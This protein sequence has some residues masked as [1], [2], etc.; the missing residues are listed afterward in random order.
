MKIAVVG[1]R[2][3]PKVQ[4][5]IETHCEKLYTHLAKNGCDI[6]VFTR[7]PYVSTN[8]HTF[9]GVSLIPVNCPRS[10]FLEAIVHT[11]KSVLMARKIK[12]DIL[13][14]HAVGPSLFAPLA[15]VFGMKVVVTNHGPD[16]KRG[17]RPFPAK[18]FLRFC[19]WMG[20]KFAD[21]IIAISGN[22]SDDIKQKYGR[23][24]VPYLMG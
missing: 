21:K 15:R 23:E 14:L 3:F 2:G 22:I 7:K 5:G 1:T 6:T 10:K 12:P 13:H 16:Y 18:V 11:F 24:V 20:T 9:K 17:K 4:G 8:M 19:E